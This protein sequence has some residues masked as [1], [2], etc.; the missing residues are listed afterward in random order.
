MLNKSHYTRRAEYPT[1]DPEFS[2][3]LMRVAQVHVSHINAGLEGLCK[4]N[5]E[6]PATFKILAAA[7]E[8]ELRLAYLTLGEMLGMAEK[9]VPSLFSRLCGKFGK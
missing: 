7:H 5:W 2:A 8:D 3:P 4:I 1:R 6:R 9:P